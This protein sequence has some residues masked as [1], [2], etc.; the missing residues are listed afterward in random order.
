[1][2][3][4]RRAGPIAEFFCDKSRLPL[5]QEYAV[6]TQ[7]VEMNRLGTDIQRGLE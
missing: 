4:F 2:L 1:M 6:T 3:Q 7:A 5:V